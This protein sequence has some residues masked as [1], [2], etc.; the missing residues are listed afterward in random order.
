V[1][2]GAT[3]DK[4]LRAFDAESGE[5]IWS[6]R[7]PFTA[8]ASPATYRLREDGRQYLVVAAG[9]HLWSEPGDALIAWTLP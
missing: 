1:F 5:E 8:N 4:A 9:G 2:I 6:T 3:T 7:L